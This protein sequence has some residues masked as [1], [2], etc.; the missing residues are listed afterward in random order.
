MI[1]TWEGRYMTM[2]LPILSGT[3]RS[4]RLETVTVEHTPQGVEYEI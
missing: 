3:E 1:L 2:V 4:T